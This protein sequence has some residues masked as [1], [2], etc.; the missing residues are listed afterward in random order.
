VGTFAYHAAKRGARAFGI[1]YSKE[2]IR[3][4][5]SLCDRFGVG[6]R[7][8][9]QTAN[10]ISL[11][12]EEGSFDKIVAADFIEHI[13]ET[14]KA[15][16]LK[17]SLRVLKKGGR[18]VILTPNKIRED[19]AAI[20]WRVRHALCGDNIPCNIRHFGLISRGKF[21][22]LLRKQPCR[23]V[24]YFRDTTRPYLAQVPLIR[25]WLSLQ[26]VWVI[27]KEQK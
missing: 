22:T 11:P 10:A 2:S 26:L 7:V 17:E 15:R 24:F 23:F 3:M 1:D 21:E 27:Q 16:C 18:L 8:R 14:D 12:F 4:A 6:D 13:N 25:H 20:Y 19:I 9:F 5:T